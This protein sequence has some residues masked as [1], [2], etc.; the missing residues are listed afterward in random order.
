MKNNTFCVSKKGLFVLFIVL[1]LASLY[2][3][4]NSS[5]NT[6]LTLNSKAAERLLVTTS[7]RS[8]TQVIPSCLTL[9]D[10]YKFD[11]I[12]P[13]RVNSF[14][15]NYQCGAVR[16]MRGNILL[17]RPLCAT[18]SMCVHDPGSNRFSDSTQCV[19]RSKIDSAKTLEA[20]L[21]EYLQDGR[22][23]FIQKNNVGKYELLVNKSYSFQLP[24]LLYIMASKE[25]KA[26]FSCG[27]NQPIINKTISVTNDDKSFSFL[28]Q[29]LDTNIL[30]ANCN[31]NTTDSYTAYADITATDYN[32]TMFNKRSTFN[33]SVV[34]SATSQPA[35]PRPTID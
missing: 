17:L 23:L 8:Q 20:F 28:G 1:I 25:I 22:F 9:S 15:D 10:A 4:F 29:L 31:Y 12:I 6:K 32:G 2:F 14:T 7:T 11:E 3:V 26:T 30:T 24:V 19:L 21:G 13:S 34:G 27:N 16:S 33:V 18:N 5:Q 35:N